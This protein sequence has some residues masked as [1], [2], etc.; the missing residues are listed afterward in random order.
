MRPLQMR[1][2][3]VAVR[4]IEQIFEKNRRRKIKMKKL[5]LA[6]LASGGGT[7]LQALIDSIEQGRLNAEIKMV[8][9]N[10]SNSFA[11]ER[12]RK[13]KI[14]DL[15]LSHK[16]FTTPEEFDEKLLE[17]LKENEI[18]MIVLAGY[19]KILSPKVIQTY[20]NKIINI[21]P[22]LL[23]SFGGKGMYGIHVHEAVINSGVKITGVTVHLVDEI[24]D[25][26]AIIMQKTV[27]VLDDDTPE[28]LAERVLQVEHQTY[29]EAL[30]L[31]A[32]DKI[33][34]IGNKARLKK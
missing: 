11:L 1:K 24:Y 20:K 29:S 25:H 32:L 3:T 27:S 13:H 4:F 19:M 28:T 7:N 8:I 14:K 2:K 5:N 22:A 15:H 26:G 21:H 6:V 23:P 10:N 16:Q 12:A 9:S 34:I 18:D 30:Q 33:E 31:F 17:V